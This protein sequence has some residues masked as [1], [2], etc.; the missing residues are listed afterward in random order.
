MNVA[1]PVCSFCQQPPVYAPLEDMD[2]YGWKVYYCAECQAEYVYWDAEKL[3]VY[4]DA[5]VHLYT[6]INEKLYRWSMYPDGSVRIWHFQEPGLPG[7][8]PNRKGKVLLHVEKNP[9]TVTPQNIEA[10]IRTIL[11]FS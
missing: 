2:Q 4:Q 6:F 10:K 11:L 8:R 3:N 1:V 7:V 9:P 5:A